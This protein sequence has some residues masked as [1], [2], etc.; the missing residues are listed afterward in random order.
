MAR[1]VTLVNLR[2]R[3]LRRADLIGSAFRTTTAGGEV[4]AI[5]NAERRKVYDIQLLADGEFALSSADTATTANQDTYALP[6]TFYKLK[7]VDAFLAGTGGAATAMRQYRWD[8][9]NRYQYGGGWTV[10]EPLSYRLRG[11]NIILAPKPSAGITFRVYYY[12]VVEDLDDD[13]DT[14]ECTANEDELIVLGSA[15]TLATEEGDTESAMSLLQQ[16]AVLKTEFLSNAIGRDAGAC[17]QATDVYS[18]EDW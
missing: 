5:I 7:G 15:A 9:R 13:A 10:G 16:Y 14:V 3:V 6:A 17:S 2:N 12:P 11:G 4:D 1:T 8:E 18:T